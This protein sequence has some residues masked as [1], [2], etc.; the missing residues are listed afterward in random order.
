MKNETKFRKINKIKVSRRKE[1]QKYKIVQ[2]E[3]C[4]QNV[5]QNSPNMHY[6]MLVG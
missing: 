4:N 6:I 5:E 2:I 3:H 1:K